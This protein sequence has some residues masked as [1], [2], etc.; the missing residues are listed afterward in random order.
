MQAAD[1]LDR[2][3]NVY[4]VVVE[5]AATAQQRQQGNDVYSYRG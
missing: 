1:A 5:V 4:L 3:G 2:I